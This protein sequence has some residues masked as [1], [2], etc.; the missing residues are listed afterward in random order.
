MGA[1]SRKTRLARLSFTLHSLPICYTPLGP[2]QASRTRTSRG[3]IPAAHYTHRHT[4]GQTA[5]EPSKHMWLRTQVRGGW[6][7][8]AVLSGQQRPSA[9]GLEHSRHIFSKRKQKCDGQV[10]SKQESCRRFPH[11]CQETLTS[12]VTRH[13]AEKLYSSSRL[14]GIMTDS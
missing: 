9:P 5:S 3:R 13:F 12:D 8:G 14:P 2:T 11:C 10:L 7:Y 6:L 1:T 4:E